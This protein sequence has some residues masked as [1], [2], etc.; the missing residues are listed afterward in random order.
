[1][2]IDCGVNFSEIINFAPGNWLPIGRLTLSHYRNL[3]LS[4]FF[5]HDELICK[6]A[7]EAAFLDINIAKAILKD[8]S[9]TFQKEID[10]RKT[11]P[12]KMKQEKQ[13]FELI[14]ENDRRCQ[15][16]KNI[17]FLSAFTCVSHCG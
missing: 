8:I 13:A 4:A 14:N 1:M 2:E 12:E 17:I 7:S 16:C 5:S 10:L 15:E 6:I 3:G 9:K 11:L